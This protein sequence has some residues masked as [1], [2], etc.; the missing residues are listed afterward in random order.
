MKIAE[1]T[2]S[3][4]KPGTIRC[5]DAALAVYLASAYRFDA[6]DD[7]GAPPPLSFRAHRVSSVPTPHCDHRAN[8]HSHTAAAP[9]SYDVLEMIGVVPH[10]VSDAASEPTPTIS[11]PRGQRSLPPSARGGV[12]DRR[13]S[14]DEAG[15]RGRTFSVQVCLASGAH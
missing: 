2:Q 13:G 8:G 11:M 4:A 3:A 14:I 10:D 6:E 7:G 12:P 15:T 5:S 9:P 1:Q